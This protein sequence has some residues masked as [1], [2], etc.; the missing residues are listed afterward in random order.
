MRS[1][2]RHDQLGRD[3]DVAAAAR[4][5]SGGL[6]PRQD[7]G[8]RGAE[9]EDR[10]ALHFRAQRAQALDAVD[11]QQFAHLREPKLAAP[12]GECLTNRQPGSEA[13]QL[14]RHRITDA[15]LIDQRQQVQAAGSRGQHDRLCI[16]Q[17]LLQCS[18]G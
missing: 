2:S 17:R 9:G 4:S 14:R 7:A 3:R 12:L 16:Q 18:A 10:Q 6:Q 5:S 13:K 15:H 11:S 1:R 8:N